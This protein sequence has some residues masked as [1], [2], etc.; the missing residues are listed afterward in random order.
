MIKIVLDLALANGTVY[1]LDKDIERT[2]MVGVANGRIVTIG[3]EATKPYITSKTKKLDLTGKVVFPGFIDAHNHIIRYG[4]N[5]MTVDCSSPNNKSI[6]DILQKIKDMANKLPEGQWIIGWGYD[7]SKLKEKR[8]PTRWEL[9]S[10]APNHPVAITRIC[11]HLMAANS[12]ALELAGVT[13]NTSDPEGGKF[14]RDEAGKLTGVVRELAQ[15]HIKKVIPKY[16]LA[17]ICNSIKLAAN[18]YIKEGITSIGEAGVGFTTGNSLE[19]EA[20]QLL[21]NSGD[22]K[23]RTYLMIIEDFLDQLIE[24]GIKTGF[25]DERLKIGPVKMFLDGGFGGRT[26]YLKAPYQGSASDRGIVYVNQKELNEKVLKVHKAGFQLAIHA[27]G[28]QA[29]ENALNAIEAALSKYPRENHRHRI[30]HCGL[31]TPDLMKRLKKLGVLPVPQPPFIYYLGD[32]YFDSIG[33]RVRWAYPLKTYLSEGICP[34]GSSD[35]PVV[36]GAPMTGIHA[37]VNRETIRGIVIAPEE[38]I[39]V[40]E[41][42]K[43]YTKYAAY[44]SF[45]ENIK[46]TI[47]IGKL[48]DFAILDQDPFKVEAKHLKDI[49][50]VNTIIGGEIVS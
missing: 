28:D 20:F 15:E 13:E 46:G 4:L 10:V 31:C 37:A 7:D 49:K 39:S 38:R 45:E 26:A 27:I 34:A 8:H 40:L 3:E 5:L 43:M 18:S 30:E 17:D 35:R 48:A 50:V 16:T 41:A 14:D 36:S 25:G 9:D 24:L 29:I 2:N 32:S 12:R 44:A 1:T 6:N 19:L 33:N 42:I 47:A 11:V 22:L 23:L 21:K